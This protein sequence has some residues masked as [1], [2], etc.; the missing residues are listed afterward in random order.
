MTGR[1][2]RAHPAI[3]VAQVLG[4]IMEQAV[5]ARLGRQHQREGRIAGDADR[6]QRVH[7]HGDGQASWARA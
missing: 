1:A 7:L 6:L 5:P 2:P 3:L 4:E